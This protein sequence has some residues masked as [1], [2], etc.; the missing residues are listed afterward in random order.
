MRAIRETIKED[1]REKG[2][3]ELRLMIFFKRTFFGPVTLQIANGVR[4]KSHK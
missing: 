4:G 1:V 3:A 2:L